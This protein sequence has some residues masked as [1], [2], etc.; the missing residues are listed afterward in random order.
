[1]WEENKHP[2]DKS[3]QFTSK[4]NEG[5]GGKDFQHKEE[6][7]KTVNTLL[8]EGKNKDQIKNY[9]K[10]FN[11]VTYTD[12]MDKYVDSLIDDDFDNDYEEEFIDIDEIVG[13]N[14]YVYFGIDDKE[15]FIDLLHERDNVP[16]DKAKEWVEKNWG[17]LQE[18]Q[19]KEEP[20]PAT[21]EDIAIYQTKVEDAIKKYGRIG[22]GLY[23][24]LDDHHLYYDFQ[25]K[26]V[27]SQI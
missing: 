6:L 22:G 19:N 2:R 3:G 18:Y 9:L 27:K 20:Q 10:G 1:M 21:E 4:G 26:K 14:E 5:Q 8:K 25:D 16:I 17:Q 24:E 7:T 15:H 13:D 23:D 12:E 11:T